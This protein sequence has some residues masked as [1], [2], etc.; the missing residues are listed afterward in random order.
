M[1]KVGEIEKII[2][3]AKS[4]KKTSEKIEQKLKK[5]VEK[6]GEKVDTLPEAQWTQ[7]ID[8]VS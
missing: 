4:K 8:S 2:K 6:S 7:G 5:K 3:L 1:K